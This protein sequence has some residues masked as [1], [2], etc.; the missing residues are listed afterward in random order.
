LNDIC[1]L[2]AWATPLELLDIGCAT[3][4]FLDMGRKKGLIARGVEI[5]RELAEY[6]R[7]E[8]GLE[9][10]NDIFKASYPSDSFDVVTLLD[11]IEHIPIS[12]LSNTMVEIYRI[13]RPGGV[14]V[15]RTPGEDAFLRAMAKFIFFSSGRQIERPMHLFYSFEHLSSFSSHTLTTFLTRMGFKPYLV[16]RQ[17]ENPDRLNLHPIGKYILYLFYLISKIVN[18]EHKILQYYK[19]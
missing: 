6:A 18:K 3:G 10:E 1:K 15:I 17:E 5:S 19:K 14:L 9:V 16:K 8:F 7:R 4:V 12:D 11:V 2:T 13:L